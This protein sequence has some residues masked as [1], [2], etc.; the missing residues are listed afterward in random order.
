MLKLLEKG[1]DIRTRDKFGE[2]SLHLACRLGRVEVVHTLLGKGASVKAKDNAGWTPL[3]EACKQGNVDVVQAL[4]MKGANLEARNNMGQ[5]PYDVAKMSHKKSVCK[6]LTNLPDVHNFSSPQHVVVEQTYPI[7]QAEL[8]PGANNSNSCKSSKAEAGKTSTPRSSIHPTSQIVDT[9]S[10][11]LDYEDFSIDVSHAEKYSDNH[12]N[13]QLTEDDILFLRMGQQIVRDGDTVPLISKEERSAIQTLTT[14]IIDFERSLESVRELPASLAD[15]GPEVASYFFFFIDAFERT[16]VAAQAISTGAVSIELDMT[17]GMLHSVLS[18]LQS[19]LSGASW[20]AEK[21][22]LPFVGCIAIFSAL[23]SHQKRTRKGNTFRVFEMFFRGKSRD[24]Y[25]ITYRKLA[26]Q[27]CLRLDTST[28]TNDSRQI[29]KHKRKINEIIKPVQNYLRQVH[30]LSVDKLTPLEKKAMKDLSVITKEVL[31]LHQEE[32]DTY[33]QLCT[34]DE[35]TKALYFTNVLF[36]ASSCYNNSYPT[37]ITEQERSYELPASQRRWQSHNENAESNIQMEKIK[38]LEDQIQKLLKQSDGNIGIAQEL[39]RTS[40]KVKKLEAK[41][42][43]DKDL[44]VSSGCQAQTFVTPMPIK[45]SQNFEQQLNQIRSELLTMSSRQEIMQETQEQHN[46]KLERIK[47]DAFIKNRVLSRYE[48]YEFTETLLI[49]ACGRDGQPMNIGVAEDGSFRLSGKEYCI[50]KVRK[51][52]STKSFWKGKVEVKLEDR[53]HDAKSIMDWFDRVD[54]V[55]VYERNKTRA[56]LRMFSDELSEACHAGMPRPFQSQ[57][58]ED[59]RD[60]IFDSEPC[61]NLK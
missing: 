2:T 57:S 43:S 10:S 58:H 27:I 12:T 23:I 39:Q 15:K 19:V 50:G 42:K 35:L 22:N 41:F 56:I 52:N 47:M 34:S 3:H 60:K 5:T 17:D 36:G 53:H 32:Q 4:L 20:V 49:N 44:T 24:E 51:G 6:L 1:A 30:L 29:G 26:E 11:Q 8:I 37:D 18:G 59:D 38:Y 61:I 9:N 28:A 16:F 54:L 7:V 45:D 31:R 21:S 55:P 40:L 33:Q 48:A 46:R 25:V 13:F 14:N